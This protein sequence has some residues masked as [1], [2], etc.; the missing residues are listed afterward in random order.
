MH[1]QLS[2]ALRKYLSS[3]DDDDL[4]SV[5]MIILNEHTDEYINDTARDIIDDLVYRD[6]VNVDEIIDLILLLKE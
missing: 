3:Q 2:L 4:F 6:R 5:L 1:Q